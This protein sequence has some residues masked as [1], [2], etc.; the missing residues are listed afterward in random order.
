MINYVIVAFKKGYRITEKGNILNPKGQ[1]IL[2]NLNSQGYKRF[3]IRINSKSTKNINVHRLQGFQKYGIKVF[4]KELEIRHKNNE[5]L[6][7]SYDNILIGNHSENMM[8]IPE[9][10][11]LSRAIYASSF[12][13]KHNHSEIKKFHIENGNSYKKTMAEF[14]VTSKGT[15]NYILNKYK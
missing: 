7:N 10:I 4:D 13:T 2:G 6:D 14:S 1:E 8:D 11:R 9:S 5:K 12:I 3:T 15:L